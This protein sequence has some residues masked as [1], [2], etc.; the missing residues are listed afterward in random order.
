MIFSVCTVSEVSA[1]DT[2]ISAQ[3]ISADGSDYISI[4]VSVTA[5]SLVGMAY[6]GI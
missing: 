4:N 1:V 6:V 2:K 5:S 3:D